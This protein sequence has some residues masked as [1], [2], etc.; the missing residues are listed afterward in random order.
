MI[1]IYFDNNLK[2]R[3][4][5]IYNFILVRKVFY[6]N[7]IY[8]VDTMEKF[9]YLLSLFG[10][11][12]EY[13][14]LITSG[15]GASIFLD[16][17]YYDDLRIIDF[18]IYCLDKEKY[19]PLQ[20]KYSRISLI[21]NINFDNVINHLKVSIQ[22]YTN[23][24]EILKHCSSFLL[25]KEYRG[26]PLKIHKRLSQFFDENYN[27]PAIDEKIKIRLLDL[28][29]KIAKKKEDYEKAKFVI[30]PIDNEIDLIKSYT[31]E[32]IIVYFLNK[33]LREVDDKCIEFAGL[34]NYSIYKYYHDNPEIK[35]KKDITLYRKIILS[36][37]DLYS[38]DLFEGKIICFPAFTSTSIDAN[39]ISFHT[40]QKHKLTMYSLYD[41]KQKYTIREKCVLMKFKYIYNE[42]NYCP[43]FDINKCSV[44]PS[45]KEYIFPPFSFFRITKFTSAEGTKND[46]VIIE[47]EVIPRKENLDVKLKSGG[48]IFY[49]KDNNCMKWLT[50]TTN[51]DKKDE[52]KEE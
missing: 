8:G 20:K 37:K 46:P 24:M 21:E 1:I 13:Y 12:N 11:T 23:E 32:S 34:L 26:I 41:Q 45:E 29:N 40:V 17:G 28:L 51:K 9:K 27:K 47:L 42:S 18:V 49:D 25:E 50:K 14:Y 44:I 38:Y 22:F 43:A 4:E 6:G 3:E 33:C 10:K 39:S 31:C 48:M 15:S 5:N 16:S 30:E 52:N 19:I 2:T 35:I 7:E 36:I